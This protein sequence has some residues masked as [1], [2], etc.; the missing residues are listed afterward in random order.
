MEGIHKIVGFLKYCHLKA[1]KIYLHMKVILETC[2][3]PFGRGIDSS[4]DAERIISETPHSLL[5]LHTVC[6]VLSFSSKVSR[7]DASRD[8]TTLILDKSSA[9]LVF[10]SSSA[11]RI[12]TE[13]F[14]GT[15]ALA[16]AETLLVGL[17]PCQTMVIS[18]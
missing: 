16:F 12:S 13:T 5:V 6:I 9:N 8:S 10:A 15:F 11:P 7:K 1:T 14:K 18:T 3:I 2:C 17:A 4:E